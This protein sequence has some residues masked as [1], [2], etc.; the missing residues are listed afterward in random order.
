M[1][2]SN[3]KV[4]RKMVGNFKLFIYGKPTVGK[5]YFANQFEDV[6]FLNTDGNLRYLDSPNQPFK[7]WEEFTEIINNILKKQHNFKTIVIDLIEDV[8]EMCR[9]HYFKKMRITHESDVGFGKAYDVIRNGFLGQMRLLLLNDEINVI[10]ISHEVEKIVKNR[11]GMETTAYEPNINN[12]V[13]LKL[14]GMVEITARAYK[15]VIDEKG[16]EERMLKLIT[17]NN[18]FGGNRPDFIT[19]E[20]IRLNYNTFVNLYKNIK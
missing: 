9:E 4:Q 5:S 8:Y 18:E 19:V 13:A 1:L 20:E 12:K 7:N 14:S 2:V 17:N 3:K 15:K 10:F 11:V 16:N 6:L